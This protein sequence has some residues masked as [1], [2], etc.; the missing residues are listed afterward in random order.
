MLVLETKLLVDLAFFCQ[1]ML[2]AK[3]LSPH[4]E[5]VDERSFNVEFLGN[6]FGNQN[7]I[8]NV[9]GEEARVDW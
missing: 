1:E 5:L 4:D 9:I 7:T 8:R 6:P 3:S 2:A